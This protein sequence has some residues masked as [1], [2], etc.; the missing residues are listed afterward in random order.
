MRKTLIALTLAFAAGAVPALAQGTAPSLPMQ[1]GQRVQL[2]V[3][4]LGA[5]GGVGHER[6]LA[7]LGAGVAA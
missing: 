6:D 4:E 1:I 3:G 2:G 5:I 7:R